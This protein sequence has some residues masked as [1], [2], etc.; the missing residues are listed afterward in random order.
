MK[1]IG[2]LLFDGVDLLDVGGPYE[3]FL[4][5]N[6]LAVR[7]GEPEPFEIVTVA[8]S[9]EPVTSYGGMALVPHAQAD[10]AGHL[11]VVIVPGLVEVDRALADK[12]LLATV[13]RLTHDAMLIA[14][15]CTG[16]FLLAQAGVVG[17]RAVTTHHE[18][19]PA[20]AELLGDSTVET[21]RWVDAGTL[22]TAGGLSSGIAMAL[23][24]VERITT[25]DL[26]VATARQLAYDWDPDDG[27]TVSAR[28]RRP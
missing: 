12:G 26:A 21:A 15:V 18:D 1:R 3:V 28:Q 25:R 22:V 17:G 19:V 11:D 7:Q 5:A 10:A 6:R 2:I 20:L 4:T 14:S 23:H 9:M 8:V 16:A 13:G 27:V 24:L